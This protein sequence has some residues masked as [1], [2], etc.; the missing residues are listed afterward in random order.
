[1]HLRPHRSRSPSTGAL[2]ARHRA[3][4]VWLQLRDRPAL[5]PGRRASTTS[6]D[7][8]DVL[9]AVVVSAEEGSGTFVATFSNNDNDEPAT[10]EALDGAGGGRR[11]TIDEFEPIEIPAGGLVNLADDGGIPVT[12]D[13]AAGD[14]VDVSPDLRQRRGRR[15]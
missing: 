15:R 14:F 3:D 2:A 8:V 1:M 12:G 5:H 4:L 7:A 10:V 13:F 6:D 11:S 9:G